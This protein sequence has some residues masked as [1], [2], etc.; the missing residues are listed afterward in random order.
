MAGWKKKAL[1]ALGILAGLLAVLTA[2]FWST[3]AQIIMFIQ[4]SKPPETPFAS[5]PPPPAPDYGSP[6]SWAALPDRKAQARAKAFAQG[7]A[8]PTPP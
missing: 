3:I 6:A 4:A 5:S 2:V 8:A 7:A 1:W